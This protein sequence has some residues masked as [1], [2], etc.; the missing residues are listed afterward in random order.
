MKNKNVQILEISIFLGAPFGRDDVRK[1][2][3]QRNPS[4]YCRKLSVESIQRKYRIS[5]FLPRMQNI[6]NWPPLDPFLK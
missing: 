6:G 4:S 5:T 3:R 1:C 2:N